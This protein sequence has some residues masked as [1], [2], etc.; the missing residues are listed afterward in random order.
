MKKSLTKLFSLLLT[1]SMVFGASAQPLAKKASKAN[2][3]SAKASVTAVAKKAPE[4]GKKNARPQAQ[5][6]TMQSKANNALRQARTNANIPVANLAK[7]TPLKEAANVP[8]LWG[9][10]I[11][12]D[13]WAQEYTPYGLYTVPSSDASDFEMLVEGPSAGHGAVYMDGVYYTSEVLEF[14]GMIFGAEA[15]GYDVESG[16]EVYR[17]EMGSYIPST[18]ALDP[19]DDTVYGIA[20]VEGTP[21]LIKVYF[22][23]MFEIEV[24]A[25]V[26]LGGTQDFN[27]IA[28]DKNG[29]LYGICVN[30]EA[31]ADGYVPVSSTLVSIDKTSGAVTE[32][33]DTGEVPAYITDSAIDPMTGKMY[34]TLCPADDSGWLCEVDLTTGNATR[35]YQFPNSEEVVGLVIP[36]P[37]AEPNAPAAATDL[38]VNFEGDALSGTVSF[39]VP[40][41]FFDGSAASGNVNYR[42][43]AN[44][45]EVA[46]GSVEFGGEVSKPV[47]VG[48]NGLYTFTVILSNENGDSPKAKVNIYVGKDIPV[49]TAAILKYDYEEGKMK[50]SWDSVDTSANGG[51]FNK[52]A[53]T[54][55]VTRYPGGVVVAEGITA[56]SF[57]ESIPEPEEITKYFYTVVVECEGMASEVAESNPVVLG[58][59][60]PPYTSNFGAD[61]LEGYTIID[62]NN[63]GI[64]FEFVEGWARASYNMRMAMDDWLITPPVKLEAGKMYKFYA[65]VA[66]YSSNYPERIEVK[67]GNGTTAADM[68]TTLVEPTI[69]TNSSSDPVTLSCNLIPEKSGTYF[70]GFHGISDADKFYLY[71]GDITIA[72]PT[73]ALVP[74]VVDNLKLEPWGSDES[75]SVA[76]TFTTPVMTMN[77]TNLASVTKAEV[78]RDGELIKTF[79]NPGAGKELG[80]I[81]QVDEVGDYTYSVKC[82]NEKGAGDEAVASIYVGTNYPADLVGPKVVE[83]STPGE[84]TISWNAVTTDITG[85]YLESSKVRYKVYEFDGNTRVEIADTED[86]S[87]TFQAVLEGE[88]AFVQYAVFPY[89]V[90][91]EGAGD[92]TD[93]I[94]AG[95]PY[96][97]YSMTSLEDLDSYILG[98]ETYAGG[99]AGIFNDSSFSDLTSLEGDDFFLY[100]KGSDYDSGANFFTGKIS[101]GMKN[102]GFVFYTY[103]IAEDDIN[104]IVVGV[105]EDGMSE[106]TP[107]KTV[108][109]NET[110][111]KGW[112]K[113]VVDL[114]AYANKVVQISFSGTVQKY[115]YTMFD[116]IKVASLLDN[117]L[118]VKDIAAPAKANAGSAYTV[119]V[120]VFNDGMKTSDNYSVELYADGELVDTKEGTALES[121]ATATFKFE[122]AFSA[123]AEERVTYYAYVVYAADENDANNQS[124]KV[125][126]VPVVSK[127]PKVADLAGEAGVDGVKLTWSEPDLTGAPIEPVT[128]DFEDAEAFANSYGDWTFVDVDQSAVGGF[129][130]MDLPG[131]TPGETLGSFWI[132]DQTN[133]IGNQ[134]FTA[135]SGMKYLFGLFRFDDGQADDWA[136]SPLLDGSE[137]TI[138]FW[139]KSYSAD[140]PEKIEVYVSTGSVDPAD[141]TLVE[142]ST[143]GVVPNEWTEYSY[144]LPEGTKHFAI[145]SCAASSFMLMVDDVTYV[146]ADPFADL[147]IVGYNV[148]RNGEKINEAP[149]AE[150][151]FVDVNVVNG[152]TYNYVV[153]VVYAKGESTSNVESAASNAVKVVAGGSGV[154]E[155]YAGVKV[156][157]ID[158]SVVITG[159]EGQNVAVYTA[160]G[161]TLF[162]GVAEAK[163]VVPASKG[164]YLVKVNKTSTKVIVK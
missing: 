86:T 53:V 124:A 164:I 87:Y 126:V 5:V 130:G 141:F 134:T 138:S 131:I 74:G 83:T 21:C 153:T 2:A 140:Y 71:V 120:E 40:A 95:T 41:T 127:L 42:I 24:V 23:S 106:Y 73:S 29:N 44:D 69:I 159:A 158:Q 98:Y 30:F 147:S 26:E 38:K 161:K 75:K 62:G 68:T 64:T 25:P 121:G 112:N 81:D 14:M 63:D 37:A 60:Y 119:D 117:D 48:D 114:S 54:Y 104:E 152:E 88:Q 77:G 45:E 145:R 57:E 128:E 143:V 56:T 84:V 102:P 76:V 27:S 99:A 139:A 100:A 109:V 154:G 85:R 36:A 97:S 160:D 162:A 17:T 49:A 122:R 144:T 149:V 91:G 103:S 20:N 22:D 1:A 39:K 13:D 47:A 113:V 78:Y 32:I 107:V 101:I 123:I 135:H 67:M 31:T 16:E 28:F 133:G 8:E 111:S 15:V 94:A 50:L 72:A 19:S 90:R 151:E 163:T 35:I 148:Y 12:A 137:Q 132:W 70:I 80:C 110:G 61:G 43:L 7:K 116:G 89:T 6:R 157:A 51:Y 10:V 142:G 66:A 96:T 136:I 4:K 115:S 46:N 34:W 125:E 55:T 155:L 52:D 79:N 65:K 92:A 18:M 105:C 108:V 129:Q 11:F 82:Y 59:I 150:T 3:N 118:A 9:S 93:M 33:G 146:P 156:V 58:S